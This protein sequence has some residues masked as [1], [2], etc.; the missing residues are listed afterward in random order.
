MSATVKQLDPT[1]VEL[2]IPIPQEDLEAARDQAYRHLVKRAKVPGF[3]PGKVPRGIFEQHYG[4]AVIEEHALDELVPRAYS[5][6]IEELDLYPIA[7]PDL[8]LLPSET[9]GGPVLVKATVSVRPEIALQQYKGIE[10]AQERDT[11]D[12]EEVETA[13]DT[14][15]RDAAVLVP[16]DR[17]IQIG[18][19]ATLDYEGKIDGRPFEGGKAEGSPTEMESDR[20]IPGFIDA[21]LGMKTGDTKTFDVT[22]PEDFPKAELAGKDAS[23]T[24]TVHEIKERELPPL[25]DSFAERVAGKPMTLLELKVDLRRRLDSVA[26]ARARRMMSNNVLEKVLAGH[27]FPLPGVL[28]EREIDALLED[29]HSWVART[30]GADPGEADQAELAR[31]WTAYLH[32]I[33]KTEEELRDGFR[34]EA[35]RRVKTSLLLAEIAQAEKVE[36]TREDIDRELEGLAAQY[37]QPKERMLELLRPNLPSLVAGIVRTKTIDVLLDEAKIVPATPEAAT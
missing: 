22:F 19:V 10:V 14:L 26:A 11:A 30:Y 6:A 31:R 7:N 27:D 16:V 18:D 17:G 20:F 15:R 34:A 5:K 8:E 1:R 23:F 2:E 13:L 35:E 9:E 33:G 4:R 24:V 25:D 32:D 12:D 37:R 3:R 29:T 28:V 21:I 36:A